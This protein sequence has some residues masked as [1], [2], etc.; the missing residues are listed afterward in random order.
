MHRRSSL[1]QAIAVGVALVGV[2]ALTAAPAAAS[3]ADLGCAYSITPDHAGPVGHT[4]VLRVAVHDCVYEWD[5]LRLTFAPGAF[6]T[7]TTATSGGFEGCEGSSQ[8]PI[9]ARR[10]ATTG[11]AAVTLVPQCPEGAPV[12]VTLTIVDRTGRAHGGDPKSFACTRPPVAVLR[13]P[14]PQPIATALRRGVL[15]RFACQTACT[16]EVVLAVETGGGFGYQVGEG[17]IR[18]TGAG[19]HSGRVML[20]RGIRRRWR[21]RRSASI[22]VA[23]T[24]VARSGESVARGHTVRLRR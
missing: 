24:V 14:S 12:T 5:Q 3:D 20:D 19:T 11:G 1:R 22:T 9:C 15:T 16:A 18:R 7:R 21:T 4:N 8:A 23:V 13:P 6:S 10:E 17:K 2:G